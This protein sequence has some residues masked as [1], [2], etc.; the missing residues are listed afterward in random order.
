MIHVYVGPSLPADEP[1]LT[2]P[3][4]RVLPPA[5]HGDLFDSTLTAGDTVVLIDG[6]YHQTP[7]LR[8]KE[9]LA[10]L[11]RGIRVIGA[12][13]IGA[14]RAAELHPYRMEGVGSIFRAYAQG[15]IVDDDEVAV[16]QDPGA[17]HQALTWPLVNLRCALQAAE[18]RLVVTSDAADRILAALRDVYYPQRT[19]AAVRAVCHRHGAAYFTEWLD[20][21]RARDPNFGDLKR[22]DAIHAIRVARQAAATAPALLDE[23]DWHTDYFRR[24]ANHF[25]RQQVDGLDLATADRLAYQQIFDPGFRRIWHDHLDHL[26]RRD[27]TPLAE[28]LSSLIPD[29]AHTLHAHTLFRPAVDLGNTATMARLL[30]NETDA[31]RT[32]VARYAQYTAGIMT[33]A[34]YDDTTRATLLRLWNCPPDALDDEAASRGLRSAAHAIEELKRFML[35][36]L[37]D[38]A[39]VA[40]TKELTGDAM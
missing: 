16:G 17:G 28:R 20:E 38:Q 40:G 31:D 24:W 18:M 7:A 11:A 37:H 13:S 8:H 35:G 5:R 2:D 27:G 12:A 14:L 36:L 19:T 6:T 29:R 10:A 22:L 39:K 32:S 1:L 21:Q 25:A 4:L 3:E 33:E 15:R 30:A 34:V 23:P 26:S 9:I